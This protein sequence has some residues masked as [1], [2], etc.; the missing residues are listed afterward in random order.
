MSD[1]LDEVIGDSGS[2]AHVALVT[3]A[4]SQLLDAYQD[5]RSVP[6]PVLMDTDRSVYAHYGLGSGSIAAVWGAAT[7]ARYWQILRP[8][9]PGSLSDLTRATQDT[10]QLGGDFVI[11]PD[12]TLAWGHWSSGPSDR[13]SV[14]DVID[15]VTAT[16]LQN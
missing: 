1:R 2:R 7:F 13:P 16:R 10:R 6:M 11:A 5:R 8:S 3:F 15:A 9:G 14:D 4:D 12:G